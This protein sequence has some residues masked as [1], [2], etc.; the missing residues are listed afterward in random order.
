MVTVTEC[1]RVQGS[2][3]QGGDLDL[4]VWMYL[5]ART[6]LSLMPGYEPLQKKPGICGILGCVCVCVCV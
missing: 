3:I 5:L 2:L 4:A 1:D 6:L